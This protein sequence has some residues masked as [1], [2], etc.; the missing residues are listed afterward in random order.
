MYEK[1]SKTCYA[2]MLCTTMKEFH[3]LSRLKKYHADLDVEEYADSLISYLDNARS[4]KS[5]TLTG[6]NVFH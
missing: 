6:L 2:R 5:I 3:A 4:I 1:R